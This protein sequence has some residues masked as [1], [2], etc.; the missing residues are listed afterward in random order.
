[1]FQL[2]P[3]ERKECSKCYEE[4]LRYGIKA[5]A[6]IY[7]VYATCGHCGH[8]YGRIGT[9]RKSETENRVQADEKA[10]NLVRARV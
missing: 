7:K 1:M 6:S 10:E 2:H 9:V 3:I 4:K 8:E 5:E